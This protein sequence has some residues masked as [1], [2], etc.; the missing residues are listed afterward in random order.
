MA[1]FSPVIRVGNLLLAKTND[2]KPFVGNFVVGDWAHDGGER[3]YLDIVHNFGTL[4]PPSFDL[5]DLDGNIQ[6]IGVSQVINK[7][8]F[9][10]KVLATPDCRFDGSIR[11]S[12]V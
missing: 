6:V 8:R 4:I 7:D 5:Y 1:G 12:K 9:R 3:Y 11:L 10:I 2:P